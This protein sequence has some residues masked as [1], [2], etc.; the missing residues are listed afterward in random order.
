LLEELVAFA[1]ALD[2]AFDQL[3]KDVSK[4]AL[5]SFSSWD[6]SAIIDE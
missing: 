1:M 6:P 4:P 5:L 3:A 2:I